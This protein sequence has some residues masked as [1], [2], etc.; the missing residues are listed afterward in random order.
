MIT[1]EKLYIV[2]PEERIVYQRDGLLPM[3]KG[4]G[5]NEKMHRMD[6][7]CKSQLFAVMEPNVV[8]FN[9]NNN[10]CT[11]RCI[12]WQDQI[13]HEFSFKKTIK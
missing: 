7:I 13:F 1:T 6:D 3:A 12:G 5:M 2:G 9:I 8:H 4:A 10:L 11:V